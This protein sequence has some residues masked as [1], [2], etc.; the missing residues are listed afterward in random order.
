M[1]KAG[2]SN[3]RLICMIVCMLMPVMLL[4][5]CGSKVP[6]L[7][8]DNR[9]EVELWNFRMGIYDSYQKAEDQKER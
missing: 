9:I 4:T 3:R 6:E 8:S 7:T 1:M 5:A 2:R